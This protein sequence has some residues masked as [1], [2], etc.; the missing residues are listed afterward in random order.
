MASAQDTPSAGR[1]DGRTHLLAVRVYYEDTDF[2]GLVYHAAHLRFLE[3]GRSD[4]LRAIG[5]AHADL[6]AQDPPTAYALL[7]LAIEY[8]AAARIDDALLVETR[9]EQV[10]GPRLC[11]AQRI[12]RGR[13]EVVS[14]KVEACCISLAGR[15]KKPPALL[16]ERLAPLLDP[17]ASDF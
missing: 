10:R 8:R 15:P 11:I 12:L 9:Y 13:E 3:R 5:V 7:R 17:A 1:F 4:F 6:L 14:A 16:L 2:S